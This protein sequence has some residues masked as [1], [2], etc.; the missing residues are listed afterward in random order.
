MGVAP[1]WLEVARVGGIRFDEAGDEFRTHLVI[2]L[3]DRGAEHGR[4]PVAPGTELF[5]RRDRVFQ[6]AGEGAFPAGMGG[7]DDTSIGF[8]DP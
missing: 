4:D 3:A 7:A 5:H 1:G 8:W 6:D 2:V